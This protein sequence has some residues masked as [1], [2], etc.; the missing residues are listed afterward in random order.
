MATLTGHAVLAVGWAALNVQQLGDGLLSY[1]VGEYSTIMDN[2]P[3]RAA[4]TALKV[5]LL[6]KLNNELKTKVKPLKPSCHILAYWG[7]TS[8]W[9]EAWNSSLFLKGASS[10]RR[11]WG[12]VRDQHCEKGRLGLC[13]GVNDIKAKEYKLCFYCVFMSVIW[14]KNPKYGLVY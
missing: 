11:N 9:T 1:Q 13:P 7:Y 12:H 2:G 14:M 3:A 10:R 4:G 8:K 5:G 6:I